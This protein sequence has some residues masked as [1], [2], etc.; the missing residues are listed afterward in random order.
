MGSV[1]SRTE[2]PT[3]CRACCAAPA[4]ALACAASYAGLQALP[5]STCAIP[6]LTV[7]GDV[8]EPVFA[9][10]TQNCTLGTMT[11]L[12]VDFPTRTLSEAEYEGAVR[13]HF[14][15]PA[16]E[17]GLAVSRVQIVDGVIYIVEGR[18]Y[19]LATRYQRL[20]R[21]HLR[22]IAAAANR[23]RLPD[24]DL[25]ITN[26]D[27]APAWPVFG[28]CAPLGAG[29]ER[30]N[31][32]V[33]TDVGVPMGRRKKGAAAQPGQLEGGDEVGGEG[34]GEDASADARFALA[35]PPPSRAHCLRASHAER[36]AWARKDERL[37]FR[38][39]A[40][41]HRV[42]MTSWRRNPRARLAMLSKLF[43][44]QIDAKLTGFNPRHEAERELLSKFLDTG[45]RAQSLRTSRHSPCHRSQFWLRNPPLPASRSPGKFMPMAMSGRYKW[46]IDLDGNAQANRFP[47]LLH[48]GPLVLQATRFEVPLTHSLH[49]LPH[50]FPVRQ[51]F[52]DLQLTLACLRAHP[53]LALERSRHGLAAARRLVTPAN[54]VSG[55]WADLLIHYGTQV[56]QF[57]VRLHPDAIPAVNYVFT[58]SGVRER[59]PDLATRRWPPLK[60][61]KPLVVAPQPPT[62]SR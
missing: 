4:I 36:E 10:R 41:G 5:P 28:H 29:P 34:D 61:S 46:V 38:G 23:T 22:Q 62:L 7:R 40:T 27:G 14:N 16:K 52:A 47:F 24:V 51:D 21:R 20:L 39:T 8:C 12:C 25:L 37:L 48:L 44:D 60:G 2:S 45:G 30:R 54:A 17:R 57:P 59:A 6:T 49:R 11:E 15:A 32:V 18:S 13:R 35:L 58:V 42:N 50:V 26:G 56:L 1:E 19:R 53:E 55:W 3:S 43:P 9:L 31:F 33:P